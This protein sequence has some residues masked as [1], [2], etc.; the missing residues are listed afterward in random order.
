MVLADCLFAF[1]LDSK[2]FLVLGWMGCVATY[3]R[4]RARLRGVSGGD[5]SKE[6]ARGEEGGSMRQDRVSRR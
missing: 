1:C 6:W 3:V 4:T 5:C 2:Y